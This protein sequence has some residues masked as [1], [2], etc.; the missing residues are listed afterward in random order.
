MS[1]Y[2]VVLTDNIFP[3]LEIEKHMLAEVG[4]DLVLVPPGADLSDYVSDADV[5]VNTYVKVSADVIER[6]ENCKMVI[7]T[8]IGVD[9]IDVDAC[10]K[11]GILVSNVPHYCSNE[12]A[13]HMMALMLAVTRKLKLLDNCVSGGVWD[14]KRSMP[15]FSL[16]DKTLGLVGFGKIP[17]LIIEKARAF[18][19]RIVAYD[20]FVSKA[21]M[22]ACYAKKVSLDELVA[23][24][25][26]VSLHCPLNADTR[27]MIDLDV[28]R[29]MKRSAFL[30]NVARGPIV[31]EADLVTALSEGLIAGAGLDVLTE[32]AIDPDNPLLQFEQVII[33]PHC[34]WYS[35]ES[36][37]RRRTQTME[38]VVAVLKGDYPPTVC[39]PAV[40]DP[41]HAKIM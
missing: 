28:F 1:N 41:L 36:I 39:N 7:R 23:Q 16:E 6:M 2:K 26:V 15:M 9:T 8:G 5:V 27:G 18:G 17:R 4:A 13:T 29:K 21:D 34:A 3:D 14:V 38:S 22:S 11:K 32:N 10:T 35:E 40:K 37:V 20:P 24:S 31:N 30:I 12:V 25:D 33:T 19:M